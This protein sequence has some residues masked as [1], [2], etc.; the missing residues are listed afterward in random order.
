MSK[1]QKEEQGSA[2]PEDMSSPAT[3]HKVSLTDNN[4]S[5]NTDRDDGAT[6]VNDDI[7]TS[8]ESAKKH[9]IL[10]NITE[11]SETLV[12]GEQPK[13]VM[14]T[15]GTFENDS[16]TFQHH[17][18]ENDHEL[19]QTQISQLQYNNNRLALDRAISSTVQLLE[20]LQRE[21]SAR[22]ISYPLQDNSD[23][24]D[25]NDIRSIRALKR[26]STVESLN[27]VLNAGS[28]QNREDK[29]LELGN[30]SFT[31]EFKVLKL[32]LKMTGDRGNLI[33]TL[34][35][36]AISKL[37]E[38]KILS[39][40]KHLVALRKRIDDTSSKVFVTGDLNSGKST[41]CNAL[42]RRK[43]L[44]ED[45]QPCT[46]VFSEVIDCRENDGMEEVHAVLIGSEY[47]RKD[48]STYEIYQLVDLED[49]VGEYDK[50]SILKV[51]V[52][53]KRSVDRSLLKNG[54]IDINLIDAPGLN[55]D[56]YQTT[57]VFSRQE[58]ID[59]VVF[60]VSAEN[61]FTLSAREF[62]TAAAKE[63]QFIF[64]VVN[65]FDTI[66][67]KERCIKRI[68]NQVESLS[69]E[70]HKDAREFVHFVSSSNIVNN[71]GGNPGD[72]GDP[73]D[74]GNNN[75]NNNPG[76]PN[77]DHLESSLRKFVLEKR[78]LS[79]LA[80][81]KNFLIKVLG[82]IEGLSEYNEGV[83]T[84]DRFNISNELNSLIPVYEQQVKESENTSNVISKLVEELNDD[85][86]E[87]SRQ[88]INSTIDEL[89]KVLVH[90]KLKNIYSIY[91]YARQIQTAMINKVLNSVEISE[92]YAKKK[93]VEGVNK[94]KGVG[95]ESLND[96]TFLKD[97]IF[98]EDFMFQRRRH[99]IS[100]NLNKDVSVLDFF[101]PSFGG[102]SKFVGIN[103]PNFSIK[104][105]R[106]F[107]FSWKN[108]LSL[109]FLGSST[110]FLITKNVVLG[111]SQYRFFTD[112]VTSKWFIKV[113]FVG[114]AGLG[115]FFI[116]RDIPNAFKRN[117]AKK[118]KRQ[119]NELDYANSNSLRIAKECRVVLQFP[120]REISKK[121]DNV[122]GDNYNK[123]QKLV[124]DLKNLDLSINFYR[125]LSKRCK[126]QKRLVESFDLE[127]IYQV[128]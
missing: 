59:L 79:K 78:A 107:E 88:R 93:T 3:H 20:D 128:D 16:T 48:E 103:T 95:Q 63:K 58:E 42:L 72:P 11:N 6:V 113:A 102:V 67:N 99:H 64:I 37:L 36:G 75:D 98:R 24:A 50:Y 90:I 70:T 45:Q 12:D 110:K 27:K 66:K 77:F 7:E 76:D 83:F 21:S 9:T 14:Y 111:L 84:N 33:S 127:S 52:N 53:D 44:P 15:Q 25:L 49:L 5:V 114:A 109:I 41:F 118:L 65:R 40:V 31:H 115:I 35:Q 120:A 43:L 13:R 123:K 23:D 116:V 80:P 81:A 56:S 61:H 126:D 8:S 17:N 32:N 124:S 119:I 55:M 62:I 2:S 122:I 4:P 108:S 101:D 26:R 121:F 105:L 54:V 71:S 38:E 92:S 112:I 1:L 106:N 87:F 82:D 39:T 100:K 30:D 51:Y 125:R 117:F 68:L 91:D 89:D 104:S 10:D 73:G 28:D 60:V 19:L 47:N 46:S 94:I 86:Y 34:D 96:K 74:N 69:P 29:N 18:Q 97:K 57:E 85:V 22:H